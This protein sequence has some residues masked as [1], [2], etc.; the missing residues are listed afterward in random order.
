MSAT[1]TTINGIL[2][3]VYEGQVRDQLQ[4]EDVAMKRIERSSEGVFETPGGKYVVFPVRKSRNAGISYRSEGV[5]LAA[6]GS[7]GY[8]QA[9]ETLRYGYGRAKFT[10]QV[11]E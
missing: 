1:M 8:A 5:A 6:A 4:S 9:Q 3:E 7:Q 2:K 11:M 10:G